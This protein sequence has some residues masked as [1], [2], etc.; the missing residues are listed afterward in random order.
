[1]DPATRPTTLLR[2]AWSLDR[3]ICVAVAMN[4][5]SPPA[6]L[7]H[8]SRWHASPDVV[9]RIPHNPS[10]S[11]RVLSHLV[12]T[13]SAMHPTALAGVVEHSACPDWVREA[14]CHRRIKSGHLAAARL[15]G[16]PRTSPR[17]LFA[18]Y[19]A[20]E[21]PQVR[22]ALASNPNCPSELVERLISE[23]H[24]QALAHL[25]RNAG[26]RPEQRVLAGL[27][28]MARTSG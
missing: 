7:M 27:A 1:M 24:P 14:V 4:P 11:E 21:E 6:A 9:E 18:L 15:S 10:A 12:K 17:L 28:A 19:G 16:D 5:S 13:H 22:V 26:V 8:L 25:A 20:W 2:L 23:G 3:Q